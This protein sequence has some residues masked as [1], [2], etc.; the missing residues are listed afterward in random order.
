MAIMDAPAYDPSHDRM[1]ARSLIGVTVLV[2]L[3]FVI[4]FGGFVMGHGWFFSDIPAEHKVDHFFSALEARDYQKAY[5][6]YEN[7]ANWQQHPDKEPYYGGYKRFVD[8]WTTYSPVG[9]P[10]TW[11]HVDVSRS[12]GTGLFGSGIIVGSRVNAQDGSKKLFL[13]VNRKDGTLG[14]SP[15][16]LVYGKE[17]AAAPPAPPAPAAP[18]MPTPAGSAPPTTR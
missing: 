18:A 17:P 9:A 13:Y 10:I 14:E 3:S 16:I 8:D 6:I 5:G 11:H 2:I 4:G 7:D 12:D 15:H 1:V